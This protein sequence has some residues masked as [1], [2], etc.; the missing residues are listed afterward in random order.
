MSN[1]KIHNT[2]YSSSTL[3]E[4]MLKNLPTMETSV[5]AST[6]FKAGTICN[7][8]ILQNIHKR[9]ADIANH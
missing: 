2:E 1:N 7:A 8:F 9:Q 4:D 6:F 3:S 5:E